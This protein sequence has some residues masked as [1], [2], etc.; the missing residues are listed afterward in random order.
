MII[1][2]PKHSESWAPRRRTLQVRVRNMYVGSDHPVAV[3]SM[4][5]TDTGDVTA[6]VAQILELYKAGSELV[7]FTVQNLKMAREVMPIRKA[8]DDLGYD[9]PLIG[10]FH[11][12]GHQLLREVPKCADAL[13][14]YRINPGNVGFGEKH[15]DNFKSII[16]VAKDHGKPVRIGVNWGSLDQGVLTKLMDDNTRSGSPKDADD[17][18]IDAVVESAVQSVNKAVEYGLEPNM[19]IVST[20]ISEVPQ[21]VKA[22][23][24]LAPKI[25]QPLHVGL[26]EA[27]IG[28]KGIAASSAALSLLLTE[29]IGDTIRVSL[30]PT[31]DRKR[32]EE[33]TV[34][35]QILQSL[36][37]RHFSPL[38]SSC[39][40]CGRTTSTTFQEMAQELTSYLQE[41]MP[42]WKSEGYDGVEEMKVAVM[43][44]VVNG[45]GESKRANIGIS[46]PGTGEDPACIIYEDGRQAASVKA[47]AAPEEFKKRLI[48]Y[49]E[50]HYSKKNKV[51]E[52]KN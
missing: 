6:T 40:G 20:K 33:V 22:Y 14:K 44:C 31:P 52:A 2:M 51:N 38:V 32:S 43:G 9:I 15:D 35:R 34:C 12:N 27:G 30:T 24:L 19:I 16:D 18:L 8:L 48:N 50:S 47:S 21:M 5:N 45:P 28:S 11:Y 26:T 10:D 37:I 25:E 23:R 41:K 49:V 46:L 29:G 1:K 4:T 42:E 13:D 7:R 17:V 39:P 36:D 3:Q